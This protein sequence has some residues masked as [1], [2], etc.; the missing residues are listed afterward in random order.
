MIVVAAAARRRG[1]ARRLLG[2]VEVRCDRPKLF[3]STNASNGAAQALFERAGFVRSG[4]IENLDEGDPES[5][6]F[7]ALRA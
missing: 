7:K 2:A 6:F 3:T 1:V 5:V 4:V